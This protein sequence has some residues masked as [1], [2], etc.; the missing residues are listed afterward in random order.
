VVKT[1][2]ENER[3]FMKKKKTLHIAAAELQAKVVGSLLGCQPVPQ[4]ENEAIRY[5]TRT[6]VKASREKLI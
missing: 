4:F 5:P 3:S 6:I 2:D 1:I